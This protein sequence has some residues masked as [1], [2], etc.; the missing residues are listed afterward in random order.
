MFGRATITLGI[1]PHSS[2]FC[3]YLFYY[4]NLDRTLTRNANPCLSL[5]LP[6]CF[7]S[8]T[9]LLPFDCM[10]RSAIFHK[11]W[12]KVINLLAKVYVMDIFVMTVL[13][14]Q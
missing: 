4:L 13:A 7:F 1:G 11:C 6:R 5:L 9:V 8:Y 3:F 14:L 2:I 10:F 12:N